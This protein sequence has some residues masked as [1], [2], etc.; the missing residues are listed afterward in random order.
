MDGLEG[1]IIEDGLLGACEFEVVGDIVFGL[2]ETEAGHVVSDGDSLVEGF[3]DG[4][5]HDSFEIGLTGEDKDEG[6]IG[7]HFEVG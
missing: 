2:I 5:L 4:E 6:V 3:H 7:V 1:M